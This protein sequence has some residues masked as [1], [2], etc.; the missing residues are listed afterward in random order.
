MWPDFG[1][2][3]FKQRIGS[4]LMKAKAFTLVELLVV[5]AII[6]VLVALLLPAVQAARESARRTQ[7][8]NQAKQIVLAIHNHNDAI[9]ALPPTC[10]PCADPANAG[11]FTPDTS[12]FG[13]H[14]YT[15]YHFTFPD[16]EQKNLSD[17]FV[18]TGYAGG[19]YPEVIRN[20]ICPDDLTHKNGRCL[21][22][23]GSADKWGI[24]SYGGNNYVLGDP[25]NNRT[26]P[27]DKNEMSR[28]VTDGLANTVFL[29]EMYGTCGNTGNLNTAWGT[30]WAD[31]NSTWR[32]AFNLGTSK[33]GSSLGGVALSTYPPSP[34]FQITPHYY[35]NCDPQVPQAI[36]PNVIV[37][38]LGDGG[39]RAIAGN[40]SDITWQ[41][42]VDPRDGN[43]LGSDWQ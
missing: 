39:V 5:I 12:P 1:Y 19:K 23:Y 11:C 16:M 18:I 27:M 28:I 3:S 42:V 35:K 31:A 36:H 4:A 17:Q 21:T 43:T 26:Y 20:I 37:V 24:T 29:A 15:F 33:G 34:K 40:I 13:K 9:R 8:I 2:I 25:V 22:I 38:A 32:P 7:C 6:G 10:S 14:N 41:R 30:L